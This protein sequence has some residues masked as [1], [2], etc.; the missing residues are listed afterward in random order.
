MALT[1][2]L[3]FLITSDST[4]AVS[5][6]R[7]LA[8]S[9]QTTM[10][11]LDKLKSAFAEGLG[12]GSGIAALQTGADLLGRVASSLVESSK[13]AELDA[14]S[15]FTLGQ[16]IRN[17]TSEGQAAVRAS[18]EMISGLQRQTAIADDELRPAMAT[19]VRVTRD[20]AE[21]NR[22]LAL[23][24]DV[25]AGTGADLASVSDA[26]AKAQEG[27]TRALKSLA[28]EVSRL[29]RDGASASEV[30]ATLQQV[31][32][33]S[34]KGLADVSPWQRLTTQIGEA[35][36]SL[37][38]GLLPV[39]AQADRVFPAVAKG[40][41]LI[42]VA[43]DGIV[44]PA[45]AAADGLGRVVTAAKNVPG[46]DLALDGLARARDALSGGS[47]GGLQ[48]ANDQ[49]ADLQDA[50][51][52]AGGNAKAFGALTADQ[53]QVV[54]AR[55]KDS[56]LSADE[57]VRRSVDQLGQ[58]PPVLRN[59]ITELL[60]IR[61]AAAS[62][63]AGLGDVDALTSRLAGIGDQMFGG[64]R[65]AS[66]FSRAIAEPAASGSAKQT[67]SALRRID[68]ATRS[69]G[70]ANRQLEEAEIA[71]FLVGLGASSDDLAAA[72]IAERESTRS[73]AAAKRTLADAERNL[74]ELRNG[75]LA[76]SRQEAQAAFIDA[77][78]AL[79]EASAGGD[80]AA[81]LRARAALTRAQQGL[82]ETSSTAQSA[83]LAD[84]ETAVAAARDGVTKAAIDQRT[85]QRELNDTLIRGKEGSR[86]LAD[87][88]RQVED[89]QRRVEDAARGLAD[90]QDGLRDS[91]AGT[92]GA[93]KN[94]AD[95]FDDGLVAAQG[96]VNYL[97]KNNATP[98]E[99]ASA[100]DA[101]SSGLSGIA[102]PEQKKQLDEYLNRLRDATGLLLSVRDIK[103]PS[104]GGSANAIEETLR[105]NS[106]TQ[107]SIQ[108]ILDS[109]VLVDA[110]VRESNT[111]GGV[112][113]KIKA[114]S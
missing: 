91:L 49:L 81:V 38:R 5:D 44:G 79:A 20:T 11:G 36:E 46:L 75:G 105:R 17:N 110:I 72:Q 106:A 86:E 74:A 12:V 63:A 96:W 37:G 65:A 26:I 4:Q 27:N 18:E 24:T 51:A 14:R 70:D 82:D 55:F 100:I 22:L 7:R 64:A 83:K 54:A 87:A 52:R 10:G 111:Q 80:V 92:A 50:L 85:A 101:I 68:D 19:L 69:L 84:A 90:A 40:A 76:A 6:Q 71:R 39:V 94:A 13:A 66:A 9:T 95:R 3:R 59:I 97:A 41:E 99:F 8:A 88:N 103:L 23:S 57:F 93:A 107:Q 16:A 109:K 33:G 78:R 89:A 25:A 35:Q 67:E 31:Y 60:G 114:T 112:P 108:V 73:L 104:V 43:L 62:A 58:L 29:I 1:E 28:P 2:A 56:G 34:A 15:Q 47:S 30:F 61:P 102:S 53:L 42:G 21:A 45:L 32:A 77:Q 113:I 48:A 98:Q